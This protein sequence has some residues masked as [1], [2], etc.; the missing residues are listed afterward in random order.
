MK[1]IIGFLILL[2]VLIGVCGC[3]QPAAKPTTV[4][5]TATTV[6]PA[7]TEATIET[8]AVPTVETTI[9]AT[10]VAT[11]IPEANV[12]APTLGN[13]TVT[14]NTTVAE[15]TETVTA[16]MTPSTKVTT[17]HIVNNTFSPSVLMVYPGTGISWINDDSTVHSVKAIGSHAGKFNS[18]EIPK[19]VRWSYSFGEAEGTFEYADG[20]NQNITGTI[21]VKSGASLLGVGTPATYVTSSA[22]W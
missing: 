20:F 16:V 1:K 19:G 6:V 7:T 17:V 10:P 12:T 9:E 4:T 18:G 13:A 5:P 14:A 3:T 11:S 8:T 2:I 15:I 22:T 21:I